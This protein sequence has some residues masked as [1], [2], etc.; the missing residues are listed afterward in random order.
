[1]NIKFPDNEIAQDENIIREYS[2]CLINQIKTNAM[3]KFIGDEDNKTNYLSLLDSKLNHSSLE[4]MQHNQQ[5]E[6][7][8][9]NDENRRKYEERIIEIEKN[10]RRRKRGFWNKFPGGLFAVLTPVVDIIENK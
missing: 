10:K 8:D 6:I 7:R 5:K 4:F 9:K 2:N 3:S 1:M